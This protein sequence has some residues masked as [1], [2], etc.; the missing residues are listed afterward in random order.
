MMTSGDPQHRWVQDWLEGVAEIGMDVQVSL[1]RKSSNVTVTE[2]DDQRKK[3][4]D[5]R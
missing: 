2:V 5:D 1:E 3:F 4:N